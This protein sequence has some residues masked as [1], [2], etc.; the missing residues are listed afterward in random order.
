MKTATFIKRLEKWQGLAELYRLDPPISYSRDS[1]DPSEP[2]PELKTEYVVVSALESAFDTGRPETFI[3]P[4]DGNGFV[5]DFL[6]LHG[7]LCDVFSIE[8]ALECAGYE[9]VGRPS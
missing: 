8:D 9:V 4:S 1:D 3:F 2:E 5:L 6:E 7:S